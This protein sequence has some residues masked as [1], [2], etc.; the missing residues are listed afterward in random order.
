MRFSK[1]TIIVTGAGSGLGQCLSEQLGLRGATIACVDRDETRL[2]STID[3]LEKQSTPCSG[4]LADISDGEAI[5]KL[6]SDVDRLHGGFDGLINNA[7]IMQSF[8][9]ISDLVIEDIER[10]TQVN[11]W[12]MVMLVKESLPILEQRPEA[13]IVNISSMSAL[14][15]FPGQTA[16]GASKAAVR[17]FS[18]G[19]W[20][21]TQGSGISV[22]L[23]MPG[24]IKTGIVDNSPFLSEQQKAELQGLSDGPAIALAP[25]RAARKIL[26]ALEK[27]KHRI[28]LGSDA[29]LLDKLYRA[30]PI[31]T[32]RLL[33]WAR[34]FIPMTK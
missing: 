7:G 33:R 28:I 15:P 4:H 13:C 24:A 11:Y 9:A 12:G 6:V 19:L 31:S 25:D 8:T 29:W 18:E 3:L 32:T 20:M 21:E 5:A 23:V 22:A 27:G 34:R 2:Q 30:A 16:Y 17:M 10:I 14:M 1:K 26:S